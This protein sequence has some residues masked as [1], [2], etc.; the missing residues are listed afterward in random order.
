MDFSST[1]EEEKTKINVNGSDDPHYRYKMEPIET[2]TIAKNG[3]TTIIVNS[4]YI[5]KDIYRTVKNLKTCFSKGLGSKV[6]IIDGQLNIPGN[7]KVLVLQDIL[8]KYIRI[9]VLCEKCFNPETLPYKKY[10][11][12]QA[13]GCVTK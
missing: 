2:N 9:N 1:N 11:K 10:Y 8:Q 12:C 13:C 5:A 4:E 7:H 6:D 3:G